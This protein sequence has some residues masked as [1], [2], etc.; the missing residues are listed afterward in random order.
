MRVHLVGIGGAGLSAI[1][2]VLKERG[3]EVSGSDRA[4][5]SLLEELAKEGVKVFVGHK[6]ENVHGADIVLI[7]SAVPGDNPEV[8]EA[9]RLG[10]P[11]FKRAEFLGWL[12][13]G[14]KVIAVAGTHGKST[15]T[16]MVAW[17][18]ERAGFSPSYIVGGIMANSGL[19]A[20]HGQ[21]PYFVIEADEYDRTFLGLRPF[22][23][24]V[25]AL[26]MDHPD[27]YPDL[28][29]MKEAFEEFLGR[30]E[31]GG[32]ILGCGDEGN[33][34]EVLRKVKGNVITYGLKDG[35]VWQGESL[36]LG[37]GGH[38]YQVKMGGR[39]WGP[40]SL[41]IPGLQNVKN[42]VG[43][44]AACRILGVEPEQSGLALSSFR[45]LK[46]RFEIKG[47]AGGVI[48]VDDYAHHPTEIK[49]TLAAARERF[50]GREI[51][52]V[53]QPHTYSR[54]KALL[55]EF[56]SSFSQADHVIICDIYA[57]REKDTLGIS[58]LDI[59]ALMDHPD[60][61]YIGSLEAV[62]FYLEEH[63][64]PGA[65][66]ITLGAGDVYQVGEKVLEALRGKDED[67]G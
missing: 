49:V 3:Y 35:N 16:A 32:Y 62:A 48:V 37:E 12:T 6:G 63:L 51:W 7:S 5:S 64:K 4:H 41:A 55:E 27:C 26:E 25:T 34:A 15:T 11:V 2:R 44:I 29:A 61:K 19:N 60:A 8:Q 40:F 39:V 56:A 59:L 22:L 9:R 52:A 54:T 17:I 31:P 50:P 58:S 36:G 53:F 57:A 20:R 23:A 21:G 66:L 46:R 43:A 30:V 65:V 14:Y 18:L 28:E 10:I 33:V 45:G 47:E 13:Q 24:L 38:I 67:E 1:A 42:A